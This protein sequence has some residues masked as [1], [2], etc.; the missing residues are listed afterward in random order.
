M[1]RSGPCAASLSGW[2]RVRFTVALIRLQHLNMYFI[3]QGIYSYGVSLFH[4]SQYLF[5]SDSYTNKQTVKTIRFT[6]Q[7][8]TDKMNTV[9]FK[10]GLLLFLVLFKVIKATVFF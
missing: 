9:C 5:N 10:T 3:V 8:R 2:K 4:G 6:Q 1:R 7:I